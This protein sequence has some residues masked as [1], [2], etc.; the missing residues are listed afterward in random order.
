MMTQPSFGNNNQ[1]NNSKKAPQVTTKRVGSDSTRKNTQAQKHKAEQQRAQQNQQKK[2]QHIAQEKQRQPK[3]KENK[4]TQVQKHK[5][6][7]Q[8]AQQN[9]QKKK[10]HIVQE[11]QSQEKD[12]EKKNTQV[13]KHKAEQQRAQQNQQK[14]QQQQIAQKKQSQVKDK[15]KKNTQVQ[16]STVKDDKNA[17]SVPVSWGKATSTKP[18]QCTDY[19]RTVRPELNNIR[20][21]A[22]T[23]LDKAKQSGLKTASGPDAKPVTGAVVVMQSSNKK[24]LLGEYGHVGVVK[25]TGT[26][27]GGSYLIMESANYNTV[28]GVKPNAQ[29]GT[30][31]TQSKVYLTNQNIKGYIYDK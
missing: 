29:Q 28:N 27:K 5:E 10:Q 16:K 14:K 11:K 25:E 17:K 21:N 8:R 12:K 19:V 18:Y 30:P 9:Q 31:H 7:Q 22:A 3:Y 15:E 26:D 24:T 20:G 1:K 23:W 4:N 13:Q 6:E 2:Q